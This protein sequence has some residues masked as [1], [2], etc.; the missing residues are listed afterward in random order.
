MKM[1][2]IKYYEWIKIMPEE[3]H[4][5]YE[6]VNSKYE[7]LRTITRDEAQRLIRDNG[8]DSFIRIETEQYTSNSSSHSFSLFGTLCAYVI[9][10]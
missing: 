4:P 8:P 1:I 2:I 7:K 3:R 5:I 10:D 9:V 6:I